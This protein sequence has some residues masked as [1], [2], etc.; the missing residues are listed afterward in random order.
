MKISGKIFAEHEKQSSQFQELFVKE[1]ERCLK[2]GELDSAGKLIQVF[3]N[4]SMKAMRIFENIEQPGVQWEHRFQF[5]FQ[6]TKSLNNFMEFFLTYTKSNSETIK[7]EQKI[8]S[9]LFSL[10]S[11]IAYQ[12]YQSS[13]VRDGQNEK[14]VYALLDLL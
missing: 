5:V 9:L 1:I 13:I 6:F 11:S 12:I 14:L 2:S 3:F 10:S 7:E 8:Q 4:M